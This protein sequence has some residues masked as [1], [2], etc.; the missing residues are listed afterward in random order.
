[1]SRLFA[2]ALRPPAYFRVQSS[3]VRYSGAGWAAGEWGCEGG[4]FKEAPREAFD[5]VSGSQRPA[6]P[7]TL[8]P[9]A[10]LPLREGRASLSSDH[11]VGLSHRGGDGRATG[12]QIV[13]YVSVQSYVQICTHVVLCEFRTW[14]FMH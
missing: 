11:H 7:T 1:M 9:V 6:N 14:L 8:R 10:A 13:M 3:K 2:N 5:T 4:V 12:H